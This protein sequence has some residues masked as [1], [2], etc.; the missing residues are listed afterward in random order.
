MNA[1][2]WFKVFLP[3]VREGRGGETYHGKE[4]C[5]QADSAKEAERIAERAFI[6]NGCDLDDFPV[7]TP[8]S[9][10]RLL[11]FRRIQKEIQEE[12]NTQFNVKISTQKK[13]YTGVNHLRR[14]TRTFLRN[15]QNA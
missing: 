2:P 11:E 10:L 4:V 8:I 14:R 12:N 7:A 6:P 9:F 15:S 1:T 3:L 13:E 5:V